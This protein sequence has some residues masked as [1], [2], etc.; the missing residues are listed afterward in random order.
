MR[1]QHSLSAIAARTE[2]IAGK[3]LDH[4]LVGGLPVEHRG[5]QNCLPGANRWVGY[6]I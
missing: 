2:F 1:A 4:H 6:G 3:M 5:Q